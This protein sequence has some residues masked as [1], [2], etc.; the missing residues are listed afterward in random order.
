[1]I[2]PPSIKSGDRIGI[3]AP[4]RKVT[5]EQLEPA[6]QIIQ[7]WGLGVNLS[8]NL[9]SQRHSY[10][11]GTDEERLS[12]LQTMISD[13]SISAILCARG[14]YGSSRLV[15]QI[16]FSALKTSPKWI[17]GFSDITAIHLKLLSLG[18]QSIHGT[19]PLLFPKED[20][21]S[22]VENLKDTLFGNTRPITFGSTPHNLTGQGEGRMLGGNL[23]LILDSLGT[24][25]EP[26]MDGSILLIEEIEEYKYKI[27]RMMNHLNRAGKLKNLNGL[28]IG[29][30]TNVL[31]TELNFGESIE[32]II[33][34]HV[35]HYKYP[36][37]FNFPSGHENPN[38][39]W[40]SGATY[41]L[42]SAAE[43]VELILRS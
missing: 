42:T 26:D 30:M 1:M 27:D 28:V 36:V 8:A 35:A 5:R 43:K 41:K 29:H 2:I 16:D 21:A 33:L 15:D 13:P 39:A 20:S 25:S 40:R 38:L 7:A 17:V 12:D 32:D 14:G 24:S 22:S 31:D 10:L 37:V 19:M 6:I 18:I 11:A 23:S 4:G 3:I 9:F 34:N